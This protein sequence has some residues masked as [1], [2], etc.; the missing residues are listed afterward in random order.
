MELS[1]H[2]LGSAD[3]TRIEAHLLRLSSDDRSRRFFSALVTDEVIRRYV[4]RF[5]FADDAV[6][7]LVD[8]AGRVVGLAH[9]SCYDAGGE[10]RMEVAFS[11]DEALRGHGWGQRLMDVASQRASQIGVTR[12]VAMCVARNLPMRRIFDRSGLTQ[13]IEDGE[14]HAWRPLAAAATTSAVA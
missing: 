5:D 4:S 1:L 7:G 11:V 8:A 14:V 9:G 3:V 10:R 2:E 12:L 6:I 13:S